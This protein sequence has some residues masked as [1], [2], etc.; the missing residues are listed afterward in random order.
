VHGNQDNLYSLAL[1]IT[2]CAL[3]RPR[4]DGAPALEF[5]PAIVRRRL[6]PLARSVFHVANR[7][8]DGTGKARFVLGSRHGEIV[9][10]VEMLE[11]LA[12]NEPLSPAVFS[13]SVHNAIPGL[14]S[15]QFRQSG[16]YSAIS[17][18]KDSLPMACLEALLL[19][20]HEP[21]TPVILVM[22]DECLPDYFSIYESEP[23]EPYALAIKLES[24]QENIRLTASDDKGLPDVTPA[25]LWHHWWKEEKTAGPLRLAGERHGWLW[26]RLT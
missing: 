12:R 1:K 24:G 21:S 3:F 9:S 22:A 14:W 8:H 25:L 26:S 18:G 20:K 11:S 5:L 16:E 2:D 13:H 6:S 17:A 10:S 19:L 15:I 7:V 4:R 23:S